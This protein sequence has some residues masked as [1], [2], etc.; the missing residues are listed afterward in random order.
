MVAEIRKTQ[1]ERR[2]ALLEQSER[3]RNGV[4]E[5]TDELLA[6]KAASADADA[7]LEAARKGVRFQHRWLSQDV[8]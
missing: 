1:G 4:N 5:A 3:S 2:R 8:P 6:A 7:R